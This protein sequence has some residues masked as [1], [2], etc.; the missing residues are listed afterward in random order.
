[1][2]NSVFFL[3]FQSQIAHLLLPFLLLTTEKEMTPTSFS[4]IPCTL[5]TYD[6]RII[7]MQRT[8]Q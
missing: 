2:L 8:L 5:I 3:L 6:E 1:M 7:K 4:K